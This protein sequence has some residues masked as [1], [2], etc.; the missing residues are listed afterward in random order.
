M[1]VV[2]SRFAPLDL[3]E[4]DIFSFIFERNRPICTENHTI[5]Q[6]ADTDKAYSY[7]DVRRLAQGFGQGLKAKFQWRNGEVLSLFAANSI[8]IPAVMLG[9]L[10]AGGIFSPINPG[11]TVGELVNQLNDSRPRAI[12]TQLQLLETVKESLNI[13]KMSKTIIILLGDE[14]DPTGRVPHFTS[15]RNISG[16]T[17]YQPAKVDPKNDTALLVYSSGT[18]GKPKGV[19]LS[20]YNVTSNISQLQPGDQEYLTWN[21]SKTCGD[22]P[23]PK[24]GCGDRVLVCAPLFHIYG[25]TKSIINPLYTG[26]TAIVMVRFEIEKWCALVQKHSITFSYLVPPIVL[27]LCKHPVVSSYD[28]SSIRMANSGAAPLSQGMIESCLKR[29]GI[30]VKQSYGMTETCPTVFNQT[31]DDWNNPIGSAGQLLPNVE[32][33]IC[34]PS[35]SEIPTASD[36]LE[37]EGLPQG[38]VGEL[39]VRGPN[40]F[41][42]YHNNPIATADCLS[43]TGWYRTGDVGYIDARRTLFIT[44]RVKELIKYNGFQVAPAELE[45]YLLDHP[46]VNNCAVVGIQSEALSTEVPMAYIILKSGAKAA[47]KEQAESIIQ[48]LNSRVAGHKKLRGGIKFVSE[49]PKSASGKIL[50]RVLK[51][52]AKAEGSKGSAM[53]AEVVRARL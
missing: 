16:S 40:V 53:G 10:W 46:L 47:N 38:E 28:L 43:P 11:Y 36:D 31:W 18:T 23:L 20:H 44:D 50:R 27:L 26:T 37:P 51:E 34:P 29:T 8:D 13:A 14:R 1:A 17:R 24:S 22:I 19:K 35:I 39:Y 7:A 48:W 42:G 6:D 45:G 30:R 33:K 15:V 12:V 5:F 41:L 3:P 32:A 4:K 52:W 9:A 21:G 2:H 25:L 49:I